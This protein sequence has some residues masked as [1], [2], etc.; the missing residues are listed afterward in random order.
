MTK[1]YDKDYKLTIY[2]IKNHNY[3]LLN[4]KSSLVD[5]NIHPEH[6]DS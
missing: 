5:R 2:L 6:T 3:I 1:M 4:F